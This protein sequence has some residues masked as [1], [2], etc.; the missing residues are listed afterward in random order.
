MQTPDEKREWI[1]NYLG[2]RRKDL[3]DSSLCQD[4]GVHP[5]SASRTLCIFCLS[6]RRINEKKRS[7][8][9]KRKGKRRSK[10]IDKAQN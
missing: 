2:Q 10:T 9:K 6:N 3:K 8:G 7:K 1:K 5:P 4:C